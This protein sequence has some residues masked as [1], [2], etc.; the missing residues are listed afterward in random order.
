MNTYYNGFTFMEVAHLKSDWSFLG[1]LEYPLYIQTTSG[2]KR[3]ETYE[4][5]HKFIKNLFR[6]TTIIKPS[7]DNETRKNS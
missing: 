1:G 5:H 2:P 7:N 6:P 4:D 3:F